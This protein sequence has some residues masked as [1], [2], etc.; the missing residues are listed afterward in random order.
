MMRI[1]FPIIGG[2]AAA[3]LGSPANWAFDLALG[4]AV[5]FLIAD[6]VIIR[7]RL[8]TL[9]QEFK[10]LKNDSRRRENLPTASAPP[11]DT[12]PQARMPSP[13]A[14]HSSAGEAAMVAAIRE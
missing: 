5:G 3:R 2:L 6:L 1:I 10:R 7:T 13:P 14:T 4:A 12:L 8:D 11:Q 9:A